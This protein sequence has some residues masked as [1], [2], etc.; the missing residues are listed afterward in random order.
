MAKKT[1]QKRPYEFSEKVK[2]AAISRQR[3]LCALCGGNFTQEE[4]LMVQ[5]HHV[6]P[7][8]LGNPAD[9][10]D[11]WIRTLINCVLLCDECHEEAHQDNYR[12]G[13]LVDVSEFKNSHGGDRD[14]HRRWVAQLRT[15]LPGKW[16]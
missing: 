11:D 4:D 8:Q 5:F 15:H 2:R 6:I 7:N 14:E 10:A 9:P 3:G 1:Q 12:T 13:T 16:R